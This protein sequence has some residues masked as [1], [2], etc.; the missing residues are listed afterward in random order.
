MHTWIHSYQFLENKKDDPDTKDW[1]LG[2]YSAH[3]QES[4]HYNILGIMERSGN[5]QVNDDRFAEQLKSAIVIHN[6]SSITC[7]L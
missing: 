7:N 2:W 6:Q 3:L 1:G 4:L 5:P